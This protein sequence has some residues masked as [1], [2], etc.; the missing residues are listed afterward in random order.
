MDF[1]S[2]SESE[3]SLITRVLDNNGEITSNDGFSVVAPIRVKVPVSTA[4][5]NPSC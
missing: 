4:D 1:M 3:L 2:L 5:N